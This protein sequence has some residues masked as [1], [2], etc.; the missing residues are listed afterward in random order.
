MELILITKLAIGIVLA[1]LLCTPFLFTISES[2]SIIIEETEVSCDEVMFL[3]QPSKAYDVVVLGGDNYAYEII[4]M[5][6][7]DGGA[8]SVDHMSADRSQL[9]VITDGWTINHG[10]AASIVNQVL[11]SGNTVSLF[12]TTVDWSKIAYPISYPLSTPNV[13]SMKTTASGVA[14]YSM[15]GSDR[16]VSYDRMISWV[17]SLYRVADEPMF[18]YETPIGTELLSNHEYESSGYG[19][20]SVRTAYFKLADTNTSYDYYCARYYACMEPNSKSYNSGLDVKSVMN[21]GTM[22][23]HGP[24]STN[25]TTTVGVDLSYSVGTNGISSSAGLS[26][27]YTLPDVVVMNHTSTS[28]NILDIRHNIDES[29]NVGSST[30]F[31][32]PGKL[33]RVDEGEAYVGVDT[34]KSQFCHKKILVGFCGYNDVSMSYAISFNEGIA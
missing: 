10:D 30:Y 12:G 33:I 23:R 22:L 1:C 34:Y 17:D 7:L 29:K 18:D 6:E 32:E 24:G 8:F 16:S 5:S 3:S 9:V 2:D 21:G 20:T 13:F 19:I 31:V 15:I 14:C 4:G 27:S 25:G 26:W 28:K 11:D